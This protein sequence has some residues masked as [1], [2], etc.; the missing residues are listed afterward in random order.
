MLKPG[1]R[2]AVTVP[3]RLPERV[4]WALSDEYHDFPGGHIRIY[5]QRELEAKLRDAGLQLRG[6]HRAHA[7]HSPYWWIRCAGGVNEPDRL[8]ARRYHDLLVWQIMKNP[9]V[10]QA[11]DRALNPLLGKSLVVYA[12]KPR[13]PPRPRPHGP[14]R[15]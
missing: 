6:S 9:P 2:I 5:R 14:R 13:P 1:G 11:A 12:E 15:A 8:L 10:L 7:L 3:A 4:N